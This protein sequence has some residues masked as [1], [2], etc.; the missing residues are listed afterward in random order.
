MVEDLR[1]LPVRR[2]CED[3]EAEVHTDARV[4]EDAAT[5]EVLACSRGPGEG[6]EEECLQV[7]P[8]VVEVRFHHLAL[9]IKPPHTSVTRPPASVAA[10][11]TPL[12]PARPPATAAR[13]LPT[14]AV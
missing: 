9:D 1:E 3:G 13:W 12:T 10:R 8:S 14:R 6:D 2:L 4:A 11:V 5:L 7:Q